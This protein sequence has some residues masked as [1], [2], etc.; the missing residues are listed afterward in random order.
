MTIAAMRQDRK[1]LLL[2]FLLT[3]ALCIVAYVP[4]LSG[5]GFDALGGYALTLL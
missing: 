2:F 1:A 4:I 5:G 3:V